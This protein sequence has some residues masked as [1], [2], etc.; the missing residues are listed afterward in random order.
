MTLLFLKDSVMMALDLTKFRIP[1]FASFSTAAGFVLGRREWSQEMM[2]PMIGV[3]LLGSGACGLNQFQ[4]RERDRL[5]ERTK[6]RP[7]PSGR[8]EA[9]SALKISGMLILLGL[10]LLTF[11]AGFGGLGFGLFGLVWYNGVYFYLKK[12]TAFAAVVG[13]LTGGVPPLLGWMSAGRSFSDWAIWPIILFFCLWQIPHFWSLLLEWGRDYERAGW[14]SIHRRFAM[15]Q[16]RRLIIVWVFATA[17]VALI[18]PLFGAV[19]SC[20]TLMGLFI[21]GALWVGGVYRF[22]ANPPGRGRGWST[23]ITRI[24]SLYC[25]AVMCFLSFDSFLS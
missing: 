10:S 6:G 2:M 20:G 13:S 9:I 14:P 15:D 19:Q 25:L 11:S 16:L 5:M 7:I 21:S 8:L 3:F 18:A 1:L 23:P 12:R 17:T 4:E 22:L 24:H